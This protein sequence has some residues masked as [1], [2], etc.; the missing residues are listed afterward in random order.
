MYIHTKSQR[1]TLAHQHQ[2]WSLD[3]FIRT[4]AIPCSVMT[5]SDKELKPRCRISGTYIIP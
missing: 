5:G 3:A 1:P 2:T 4:L